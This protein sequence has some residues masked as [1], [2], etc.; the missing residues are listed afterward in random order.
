M[1]ACLVYSNRSE[2]H[3][4]KKLI[5]IRITNAM[6]SKF[7]KI[8]KEIGEDSVNRRTMYNKFLVTLYF[9]AKKGRVKID[10]AL[11]KKLLDITGFV[12]KSRA[13]KKENEK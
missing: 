8:D 11:I 9:R 7:L 6:M 2:T 10:E 4:N 13:E 1:N 3:E 12:E 5:K